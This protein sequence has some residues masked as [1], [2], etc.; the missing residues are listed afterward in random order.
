MNISDFNKLNG[1]LSK[2]ENATDKAAKEDGCFRKY[3]SSSISSIKAMRANLKTIEHGLRT[4]N[5]MSIEDE[6]A[7]EGSM[8]A[9]TN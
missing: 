4:A 5:F 2:L 8:R 9:S 1:L 7:P 3:H 6:D